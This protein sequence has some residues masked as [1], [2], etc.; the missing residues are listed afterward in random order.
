[1]QS[2]VLFIGDI[3]GKSGRKA[4]SHILPDLKKNRNIDLCIAN[5]ENAA[6][7][8]GITPDITEELFHNGIDV[9][10][11][12]NHI[13]DKKEIISRIDNLPRLLRPLNYPSR[14]PGKGSIILEAEN[15]IEIAV[16]NIA[17]RVFMPSLDCP[18]SI[19]E[20]EVQKLRERTH[21][22]FIDMHAE[23]TAEKIAFGWFMDGLVSA[24]IGTHTHVQT[25]DERIL[26][27]GTAYISD[28]GM[29]GPFDSV[30]GVKKGHVIQRFLTQMP[31]R[32]EP[33]SG[34]IRLSGVIVE[35][36]S[37]TG[38]ASSIERVQENM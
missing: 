12:G 27:G 14:A 6:G 25:A 3:I 18:F 34:D 2:K 16:A 9:L 22:I 17:G 5:G 15:G 32:F 13:W 29:T 30:I 26:P 36:N 21:V 19:C 37:E 11:S 28:A 10:T 7:G 33:A 1:M 8:I 31:V 20:K 24:V 38:K 35:V 23:A 4:I